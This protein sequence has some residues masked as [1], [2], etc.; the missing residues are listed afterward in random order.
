M[1]EGGGG[2]ERDR[3]RDIYSLP[4]STDK[5]H[6]ADKTFGMPERHGTRRSKIPARD[7]PN[8]VIYWQN[9]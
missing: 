7:N 5:I 2:E 6:P 3:D 8:T 1:R 4:N 9:S